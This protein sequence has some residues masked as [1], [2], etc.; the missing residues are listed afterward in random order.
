MLKEQHGIHPENIVAVTMVT[1]G[2]HV[3]LDGV[4]R[5]QVIHIVK[6]ECTFL[7][8]T[9]IHAIILCNAQGLVRL[10]Q[11]QQCRILS[12]IPNFLCF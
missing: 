12:A 9:T 4:T 6:V 2:L 11:L 10:N 7:A 3:R 8:K 1:V 5:R